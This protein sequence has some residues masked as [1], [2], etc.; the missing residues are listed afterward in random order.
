M[1]DAIQHD[2]ASHSITLEANRVD[3][4]METIRISRVDLEA[5]WR[6]LSA[7]LSDLVAMPQVGLVYGAVFAMIAIG[8]WLGLSSMGWQSAMLALGGGFMLIGPILAVGLYEVSRQ[9]AL[10]LKPEFGDVVFAGFRSL[11][12]LA[13]LGLGLALLYMIWVELAFLLFMIFFGDRPFPPID[14]FIPR[15]LFTWHGVTMLIVG[16]IAGACL[17]II[18]FSISVI[19]APMLISRPVGVSSAVI[20]SLNATLLNFKPMALWA[21]LIAAFMAV[22]IVTLCIGLIVLF[23]LIG[24]ASWHA[25]REIIDVVDEV[26]EPS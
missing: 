24:H 22:G 17:A 14:E 26:A 25:Y 18:V 11:D 15:L 3:G 10:G 4:A 9:R 13:L 5:P 8:L 19:S 20:A 1:I 7:G 16:T 21:V 2:Q 23:P 12:Q 6:W